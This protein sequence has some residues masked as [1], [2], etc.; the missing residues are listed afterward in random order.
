ML[1]RQI[2]SGLHKGSIDGLLHFTQLIKCK[3]GVDMMQL[4]SKLETVS[5]LYIL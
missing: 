5:Q 3:L 1:A 2:K 4:K